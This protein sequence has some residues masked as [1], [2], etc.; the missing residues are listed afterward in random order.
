MKI[1][2]LTD[3]KIRIVVSSSDLG[4]ENYDFHSIMNKTL[5]E[6]KFFLDI[7]EKAKEE[8]G[9]NTDGCKLLIEAFHS[10]DDVFVF[11]ITKYSSNEIDTNHNSQTKKRL[12]AKRKKL[13]YFNKTSILKFNNFDDFC[14][15]FA[16][17]NDNF[18]LN[19]TKISINSSLYLYNNTY[20]LLIKN[21]SVSYDYIK[22]F[23]C[24]ISEYV[25][26]KSFSNSFENKLKEHGKVIM[27]KN[28]IETGIKYFCK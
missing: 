9:F 27:K 16:F 15:F 28:A 26:P 14:D 23:Y 11:T 24:I 7:L 20:Y 12:R 17:V 18:H 25:V 10:F 13:N 4:L 2:K 6:Q 8:V 5:E 3:N 1:E 19:I 21:T 22:K